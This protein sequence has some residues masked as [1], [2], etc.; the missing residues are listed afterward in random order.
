[1]PPADGGGAVVS[2]SCDGPRSFFGNFTFFREE[3]EAALKNGYTVFIFAVYDVQADRLRH[4]LKDLPVTILP[5]SISAGFAL[6]EQ[7]ILVIQ[8]AEIFGRKRRIP[9]SVGTAKSAAI[10]SFVELSP[11][12]FVVHVNYG[13][14]M[15]LGIERIKAAANERDYITLEYADG[16]KLFIPIE[17]V[18]L[19]QRYIGQEGQEARSSDSLGGKGWQKRKE[20]AKKAVEELAQGLLELYSRRKAEPG[21]RLPRGHRL[22]ERVR[23][24]LPLPGDR[25]PAA[26]HRGGEAGH[27][28]PRGHGPPGLRRRGVR[29]DGDRAARRVQGRDGRQAGGAPRPDHDPRRAALRDLH[30]PLRPFPGEDRHALP[31]PLAARS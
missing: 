24:G 26:L 22:A 11:G 23:G 18:N 27:G 20:K 30:G 5:Q 15:F 7:K 8:E 2:L 3:I 28:V 21:I 9:R 4:I 14:G 12:D 19:I 13:I 29:E 25:G 1:M 6:P 17:Q 16:E 31:V 10:E